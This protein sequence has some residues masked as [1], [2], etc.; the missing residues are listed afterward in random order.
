MLFWLHSSAAYS[1]S[2]QYARE[3]LLLQY[4]CIRG[5]LVGKLAAS[6][7]AGHVPKPVPSQRSR[8]TYMCV[9]LLAI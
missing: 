1:A 3:A 9:C 7:A 2:S 6:L 4:T 8:Q 5:Q